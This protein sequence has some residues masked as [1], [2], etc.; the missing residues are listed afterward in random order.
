MNKRLYAK[1]KR[2]K[3]RWRTSKK[4]S[5]FKMIFI[6]ALLTAAVAL[7]IGLVTGYVRAIPDACKRKHPHETVRKKSGGRIFGAY[8]LGASAYIRETSPPDG[9]VAMGNIFDHDLVTVSNTEGSIN[10]MAGEAAKKMF[11]AAKKD[12]NY[13]FLI[14][15]G[16]RSASYQESFYQ[17][18]IK[19]DPDYGSDPYNNP[20]K[21]LP[22]NCTE[23]TTGLAIDILLENYQEADNG[24]ADTNECK[25]LQQNAH[26]FGFIL[27]Y[28]KDKEHITGVIYEP[29]HY[30]YVGVQ[31]ATEIYAKGL[32]LEEYVYVP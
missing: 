10:T 2:R 5:V 19:Q 22:G 7:G 23:H 27:R 31:A 1:R 28:P 20:V 18:K 16:Y 3:R 15:S 6:L 24:Y 26:K 13:K 12:F 29:W 4:R 30:R 25:W 17:E 9:L 21:I 14:T 8:Q 32:C 11:E